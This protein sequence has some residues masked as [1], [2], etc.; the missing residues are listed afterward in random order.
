MVPPV[1]LRGR[2]HATYPHWSKISAVVHIGC[3]VEAKRWA[4][5]PVLSVGLQRWPASPHTHHYHYHYYYYYYYYYYYHYNYYYYYYYTVYLTTT[6]IS[7][8]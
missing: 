3:H 6:F 8:C 2:P 5:G 7:Y 4:Q 1:W